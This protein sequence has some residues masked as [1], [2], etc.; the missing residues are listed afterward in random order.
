MKELVS[1]SGSMKEF[2]EIY[3][4]ESIV[5]EF[6]RYLTGIAPEYNEKPL[7]KLTEIRDRYDML[8]SN[9]LF[10][11]EPGVIVDDLHTYSDY[12]WTTEIPLFS[13]LGPLDSVVLEYLEKMVEKDKITKEDIKIFSNIALSNASKPASD[14]D[15]KKKSEEI[16]GVM[17]SN[18]KGNVSANAIELISDAYYNYISKRAPLKW[19]EKQKILSHLNDIDILF[20]EKKYD[21]YS[22][23][24]ET[25][26]EIYKVCFRCQLPGINKVPNDLRNNIKALPVKQEPSAISS[27]KLSFDDVIGLEN[28]KKTVSAELILP[29][30]NPPLGEELGEETAN[31]LILHGPPGTGKTMF[32]RALSGELDAIYTEIETIQNKYVGESEKIMDNIFSR[33][34]RRMIDEGKNVILYFDEI[35]QSFEQ[36]RMYDRN[37]IDKLKSILS[38][39]GKLTHITPKGQRLRIYIIGSTNHLDLLDP[40]LYRS[41]RGLA[42]EI[43]LP[44]KNERELLWQ[45]KLDGKN[46]VPGIDYQ[47]LAEQTGELS[48]ADIVAIINEQNYVAGLRLE[49]VLNGRLL[50]EC[51]NELKDLSPDDPRI[52]ITEGIIEEGIR[53]Y[54]KEHVGS[55]EPDKRIYG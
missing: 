10:E 42:L 12:L 27:H 17:Y 34:K 14:D 48:G 11:K 50:H 33:A 43:P 20:P 22:D 1:D 26:E 18:T 2:H 19:A 31:L 46:T 38:D 45:Q 4:D 6:F 54:R 41:G 13:S 53:L 23:L 29:A 39:P 9:E 24:K 51:V 3:S 47:S 15:F 28:A 32:A 37:L 21:L 16:L 40:A 8:E 49:P 5:R 55:S 7:L 25:V 35:T 52:T 36:E 44:G 30:I